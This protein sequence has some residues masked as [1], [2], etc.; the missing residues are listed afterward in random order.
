[1]GFITELEN[2][3]I[4]KSHVEN[5]LAMAK[6]MKNKFVFFGIRTTE[7][8]HIL[9]GIWKQHKQEVSNDPRALAVLLFEKKQREFHYCAVEILIKELKGKYQPEDIELIEK[10]ITTHSW[11]DSVDTIS[12][13]ILGSY[14]QRFPESI[15]EKVSNF[16]STDSIWLN[17]SAVL[18]Q[19][20]YKE[21]TDFDLLKTVC[22]QHKFSNEFFIQKAIG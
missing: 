17:R 10:L 20:G 12:K 6:Y 3:F 21:K 11:W 8:R 2:A 13:Y 4:E 1:M 15:N 14:L 22:N 18:F 9:K 16:S 5:A 19:L 7:R